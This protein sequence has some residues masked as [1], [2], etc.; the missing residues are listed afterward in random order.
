[1]ATGLMVDCHDSVVPFCLSVPIFSI[2]AGGW[3]FYSQLF[4]LF[5]LQIPNNFEYLAMVR[6]CPPHFSPVNPLLRRP[7]V[8]GLTP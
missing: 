5:C 6:L 4:Y 7:G 8:V 3:T 2:P 1:M